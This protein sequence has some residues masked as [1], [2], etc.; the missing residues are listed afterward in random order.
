[1]VAAP[2]PVAAEA[3]PSQQ[4]VVVQRRERAVR[5]QEQFLPVGAVVYTAPVIR[6]IGCIRM[7]TASLFAASSIQ[8]LL[9]QQATRGE[10]RVSPLLVCVVSAVLIS[11]GAPL[12]LAP[13]DELSTFTHGPHTL[14][15]R[16]TSRRPGR[17]RTC[18]WKPTH[19]SGLGFPFP[20]PTSLLSPGLQLQKA[21]GGMQSGLDDEAC[22][23]SHCHAQLDGRV[24]CAYHF[25][26]V[27]SSARS[28]FC[29]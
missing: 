21:A 20:G 12:R 9:T 26:P 4:P 8:K 29:V 3:S 25:T 27:S 28:I 5:I 17:S 10:H 16:L 11:K 22:C 14:R 7:L 23:L 24:D 13:W 15:P 1:M 6:C 2:H 18:S 19:T